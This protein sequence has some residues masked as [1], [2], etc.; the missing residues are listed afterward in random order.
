MLGKLKDNGNLMLVPENYRTENGKHISNFHLLPESVHREHGF[1]PVETATPPDTINR[2]EPEYSDVGTEI[3]V[4]GWRLLPPEVNVESLAKELFLSAAAGAAVDDE[5][6]QGNAALFPLW[7]E[8]FTG[9]AGTIVQD[10]G[11]LYRSIHDVGTGQNTKPAATPS[12]WTRIGNPA[13]EYPEWIQPI[14][15]HD[16]Y[17][18]GAKVSYNGAHWESTVNG[19]VWQPGVYGWQQL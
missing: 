8:N 2:Y 14:G 11:N 5:L 4:T 19:N 9:R 17:T 13:D 1:K 16:A 15:A 10:E 7:D 12:M 6:I 18:S 3:V